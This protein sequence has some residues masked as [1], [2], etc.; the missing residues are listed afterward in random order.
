MQTPSVQWAEQGHLGR[1]IKEVLVVAE[2][3]LGFIICE[4]SSRFAMKD[5]F[6][7]NALHV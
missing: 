4:I 6:I 1:V 5:Q 3:C 7:K 2:H